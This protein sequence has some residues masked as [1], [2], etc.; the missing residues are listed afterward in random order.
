[1][2]SPGA[3]SRRIKGAALLAS[4]EE[5]IDAPCARAQN[6]IGKGRQRVKMAVS[7]GLSLTDSWRRSGWRLPARDSGREPGHA[8]VPLFAT[9]LGREVDGTEMT[10]GLLAGQICSPVAVST[11]QAAS[12]PDAPTIRRGV[13]PKS[14]CHLATTGRTPPQTRRSNCAG[15][16]DSH[17]TQK[18]LGCATMMR[19]GYSPDTRADAYTEGRASRRGD[20]ALCLRNSL[21]RV[22]VRRAPGSHNPNSPR[23]RR[24][25]RR[26]SRSSRPAARA[27]ET[28]GGRGSR[29]L[30]GDAAAIRSR[31]Q[32]IQKGSLRPGL[33]LVLQSFAPE[34]RGRN[35]PPLHDTRRRGCCRGGFT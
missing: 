35:Y 28:G 33:R 26:Q 1:M 34:R 16:P 12:G 10:V 3:G 7:H 22:L 15:G 13:V 17:G 21:Q 4:P 20:P 6:A 23:S 11:G 32:P 24:G 18:L 27:T 19:D 14:A 9:V 31:A 30:I 2:K 5:P 25:S 29:T 8:E